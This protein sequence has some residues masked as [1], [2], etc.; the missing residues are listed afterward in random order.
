MQEISRIALDM[1]GA[2][3]DVVGRLKAY[4]AE[5]QKYK[6]KMDELEGYH[7]VISLIPQYIA[8]ITYKTAQHANLFK[9]I[10]VQRT[11]LYLKFFKHNS[12]L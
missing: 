6:P 11:F 4:Q 9:F 5:M 3:E 10:D 2:L 1:S 8:D 12:S 7:Q